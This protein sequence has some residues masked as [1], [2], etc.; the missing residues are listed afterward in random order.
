MKKAIPLNNKARRFI[1]ILIYLIVMIFPNT[2]SGQST[3]ASAVDLDA[4]PQTLIDISTGEG[5]AKIT[6]IAGLTR[7]SINT[8]NPALPLPGLDYIN[9]VDTIQL[10]KGA[11][12]VLSSVLV[13]TRTTNQPCVLNYAFVPGQ[14]Y[15]IRVSKGNVCKTCF[16]TYS[17]SSI[18]AYGPSLCEGSCNL[19]CNGNFDLT[20]QN[21]PILDGWSNIFYSGCWNTFLDP[22]GPMWMDMDMFITEFQGNPDYFNTQSLAPPP[23]LC[24]NMHIPQNDNGYEPAFSGN[25]YAGLFAFSILDGF[26]NN[27]LASGNTGKSYRE[28]LQQELCDSMIAGHKYLIKFSTSL[29]DSSSVAT[30]LGILFTSDTIWQPAT[31]N[32]TT[33]PPYGL[34]YSARTP[35]WE[36]PTTVNGKIGWTTYQFIYTPDS[37]YK[38]MSIGNFRDGLSGNQTQLNNYVLTKHDQPQY[39]NLIHRYGESYY[40]IDG[41]SV[42]PVDSIEPNA[43]T[44]KLCLGNEKDTLKAFLVGPNPYVT[45]NWTAT[46]TDTTLN[47]WLN[48]W[49][50][51]HPNSPDTQVVVHPSVNTTYYVTI[52]DTLYN[53]TYKDTFLIQVGG[54]FL[55]SL[56]G[57]R[58]KCDTLD[59]YIVY[60]HPNNLNTVYNWFTSTGDMIV[61]NGNDTITVNWIASITADSW[62]HVIATDTITGCVSKDSIFVRLCCVNP[63]NGSFIYND[64]ASVLLGPGPHSEQGQRHYIDGTFVVDVNLY[65]LQ[66]TL[67]MGPHARIIVTG[68]HTLELQTSIVRAGCCE[69]WDAI[70][71][72]SVNDSIII[73]KHS[74]IGDGIRG[75]V[76]NNGAV[77]RIFSDVTFNRNYVSITVN[78][79]N[80]NH[81]GTVQESKFT[82][83]NMAY[84]PSSFGRLLPPYANQWPLYGI[85]ARG[86][87]SITFGNPAA[88]NLT[89]TFTNLRYGIRTKNVNA[90]IYNNYFVGVNKAGAISKAIWSA[91]RFP[92]TNPIN[93]IQYSDTIGGNV[94]GQFQ[95]NRLLNCP[96]GVFTDSAMSTIVRNNTFRQTYAPNMLTLTGTAI[97]VDTCAGF[98][99][100]V[101]I[102]NDSIINHAFGYY[103]YQNNNC[104]TR[105]V[106]NHIIRTQ[107]GNTNGTGIYLIC[108]NGTN[109]GNTLIYL[110]TIKS[111]RTGVSLMNVKGVTVND[112]TILLRPTNLSYQLNQGISARNCPSVKITNNIIGRENPAGIPITNQWVGGIY[113]A[114]CPTSRVT[115]NQISK[116][117]YGI[118]YDGPGSGSSTVFL[119]KMSNTFT[120]I[121]LS[122]GANIGFQGSPTIA[123]DNTWSG[124]GVIRRLYTSGPLPTDGNLSRFYYR[125][126]ASG[127]YYPNPSTTS[128]SPSQFIPTTI[129]TFNPWGVVCVYAQAATSGSGQNGQIA[130]GQIQFSGNQSAGKWMSRESL[131]RILLEDST[132][133]IGDAVLTN[134][135]D[136]ANNANIG[137]FTAA[138]RVN[139]LGTLSTQIA[140]TNANSITNSIV[141]NDNVEQNYKSVLSIML[142]HQL[143]GGTFTAQELS[144]LRAIAQLCPFTDG[145]A[146]YIARGLLAPIDTTD[147]DNP[148]E[149]DEQ[150]NGRFGAPDLQQDSTFS[151]KLF[152]NPSNGEISLEYQIGGSETGR[153]EIYSAMGSFVTSAILAPG[154][155]LQNITLPQLDAGIYL[156]KVTVNGEMKLADRLVIIR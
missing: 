106:S 151:F 128:G 134:F 103:G 4:T 121:W 3:C 112:D 53:C 111:L 70:V 124:A 43:D 33:Q 59:R 102:T 6:G 155:Q 109:N 86:V 88:G 136:S 56:I 2:I 147:Y 78:P 18:I 154:Q 29:S 12:N 108:F 14:L 31:T 60:H 94:V 110:N 13:F 125:P 92:T 74:Y 71:G 99:R 8:V 75:I 63:S 113:V 48:H 1:A 118:R 69:M 77:Y 144:D 93:L 140:I 49:L 61:G 34:F 107:N 23:P 123:Q 25:G 133:A 85:D 50:I 156:Y 72:M 132:I 119:N 126:P 130:Q 16:Q 146:V 28:Y 41:V 27:I 37:N 54:E 32:I 26:Q 135:R 138:M 95:K 150:S 17:I 89:N 141:P 139:S 22:S 5:W 68:G 52:N 127:I 149:G 67:E 117:G 145:N 10:Y 114:S 91:G 120:G 35:Q 80:G 21:V 57:Q 39:P 153:L 96:F 87:H 142:G 45:Y 79:Y 42:L 131:Y 148:C 24:G 101:E 90:K 84:C 64:T 30:H 129:L 81:G 143:Y 73:S 62:L 104:N 36:T 11:C 66:D 116:L 98:L 51:L 55:D 47:N 40:Y 9:Y 15:H 122:N 44:L 46:P 97:R 82:S 152:P 115:C 20:S 83:V 105:I 100:V 38:H 76:S 7:I 19:S 137:K 65:L 58:Q